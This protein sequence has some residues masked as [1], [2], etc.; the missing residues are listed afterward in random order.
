MALTFNSP[1]TVPYSKSN[2][3]FNSSWVKVASENSNDIHAQTVIDVSA[4]AQTATLLTDTAVHAG[5]WHSLHFISDT[6][7]DGLTSNWGGNSIT[8]TLQFTSGTTV[9]GKFTGIHLKSGAIL[10][11]KL[12]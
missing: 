11:Y 2:V 8:N 10:A 12:Y 4:I 6:K 9:Y 3:A 1:T 7:F 5:E